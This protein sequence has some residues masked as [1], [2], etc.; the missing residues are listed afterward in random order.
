MVELLLVVGLSW[1]AGRVMTTFDLEPGSA[2]RTRPLEMSHQQES[3]DF[4]LE[5]QVQDMQTLSS[6]QVVFDTMI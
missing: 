3:E 6:A 5:E 4:M 1:M 2:L